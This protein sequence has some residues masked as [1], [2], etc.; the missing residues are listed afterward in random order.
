[1]KGCREYTARQ[2]TGSHF[3][4]IRIINLP[5]LSSYGDKGLEKAFQCSLYTSIGRGPLSPPRHPNS[6]SQPPGRAEQGGHKDR[7]SSQ[8]SNISAEQNQPFVLT[9]QLFL[10]S[11]VCTKPMTCMPNEWHL[12]AKPDPCDLQMAAVSQ[13]QVSKLLRPGLNLTPPRQQKP[14]RRTRDGVTVGLCQQPQ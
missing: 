3:K 7:E 13:L 12:Q 6:A 2:V 8:L 11:I 5:S 4:T 10:E 1:M 14:C 9:A